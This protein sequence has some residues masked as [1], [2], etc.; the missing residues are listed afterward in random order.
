MNA[1]EEIGIPK[2]NDFNTG[3]NFGCGYFQVT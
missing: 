1:A 2:I 3:D